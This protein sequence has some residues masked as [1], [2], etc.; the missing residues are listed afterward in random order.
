MPGISQLWVGEKKKKKKERTPVVMSL[1]RDHGSRSV[2]VCL[3]GG[4]GV[5]LFFYFYF[6]SLVA[7]EVRHLG[8][9]V[10]VCRGAGQGAERGRTARA[11]PHGVPGGSEG[12]RNLQG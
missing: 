4:G 7:Q 12:G 3:G 2:R 5:F 9:P 8:C 11:G 1:S 10:A 6:F